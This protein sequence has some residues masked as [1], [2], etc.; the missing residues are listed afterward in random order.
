VASA[1]AND[2]NFMSI[3]QNASLFWVSIGHSPWTDGRR[4]WATPMHF[5][6]SGVSPV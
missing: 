4:V 1:Q 6:Q 2:A 3:G 5:N